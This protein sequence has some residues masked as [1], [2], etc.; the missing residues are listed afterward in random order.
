MLLQDAPAAF[1]R[2]VFAVIRRVVQ[3]LDGFAGVIGEVHYA[4]EELRPHSTAFR[5][6]I[7][8]QLEV[9]DGSPLG[10]RGLVPPVIQTINDEIAGLAGTAKGQ[11][12]LSTVF[13]DWP[14][15]DVFWGTAH[16]VIGS[17]VVP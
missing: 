11:I 1:N 13:I 15:G 7:D 4:L 14:K 5:P 16:L 12:E 8:L 9:G 10:H 3:Q 2:I 6:I 17:P